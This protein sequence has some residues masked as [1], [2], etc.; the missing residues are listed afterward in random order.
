MPLHEIH[1]KKKVKN[2]A[3]L[4]V[5]VAFIG[6]FFFATI[7]KFKENTKHDEFKSESKK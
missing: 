6:T 3:L 2:F 7:V 4:A 5:L 1:K